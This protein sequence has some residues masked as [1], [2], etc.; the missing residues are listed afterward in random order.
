MRN[1]ILKKGLVFGI[2]LLFIGASVI[3]FIAS[4]EKE[5][6]GWW[7]ENWPYCCVLPVINPSKS[8]NL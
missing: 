6:G 1:N 2:I 8:V 4:S 7:N 5:G 3:P